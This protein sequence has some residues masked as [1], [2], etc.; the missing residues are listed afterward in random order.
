M[1]EII[2]N[3]FDP[4]SRSGSRNTP[5]LQ[6]LMVSERPPNLY[7]RPARRSL[8][9]MRLGPSAELVAMLTK[10]EVARLV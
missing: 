7:A 9:G 10:P 2:D 4:A 5:D 8:I 6:N 1:A 3:P